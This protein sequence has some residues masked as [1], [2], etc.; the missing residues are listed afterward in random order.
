MHEVAL[1]IFRSPLLMSAK[2]TRRVTKETATAKHDSERMRLTLVIQVESVNIDL[3]MATLSMNG[4]VC[5]ENKH[6]K[7]VAA[8]WAM[9][10]FEG[11]VNDQGCFRWEATIPSM[12]KCKIP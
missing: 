8:G 3:S 4:R 7:V 6:V 9:R 5:R 10:D 11:H 1:D 2:W 12:S